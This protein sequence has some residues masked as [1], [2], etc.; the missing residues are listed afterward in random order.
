MIER[1]DAEIAEIG[2]YAM[3]VDERRLG[4]V[5]VFEMACLVR[6][7]AMHFAFPS[8]LPGAPIER[9][10]DE[11]MLSGRDVLRATGVEPGLRRAG[12]LTRNDRGQEDAVT[13]K[14]G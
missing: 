13:P 8:D 12:G 7:A 2:V 14:D 10:D 1:E 4:C 9:D 5:A 6:I 3:G 11:A